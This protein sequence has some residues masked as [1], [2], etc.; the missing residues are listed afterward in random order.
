MLPTAPALRS[1]IG[2]TSWLGLRLSLN[3]GVAESA[4]FFA[5]APPTTT[6]ARI[7][8]RTAGTA[9]RIRFMAS[10]PVDGTYEDAHASDNVRPYSYGMLTRSSHIA[11]GN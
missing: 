11:Q 2:G 1:L 7:P 4:G 3:T 6:S 8:T 10:L 5:V 9:D